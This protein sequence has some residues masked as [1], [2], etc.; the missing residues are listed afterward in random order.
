M[1]KGRCGSIHN[2]GSNGT[3][4]RGG[5]TWNRGNCSLK[6]LLSDK[7]KR[8]IRGGKRQDET[9]VCS[10][11]AEINNNGGGDSNGDFSRESG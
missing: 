3:G 2:G 5:R 8:D 4:L 11:A 1:L 6:I 9:P 7:F 10:P